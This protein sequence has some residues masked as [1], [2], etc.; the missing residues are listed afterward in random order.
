MSPEQ[1]QGTGRQAASADAGA[2]PTSSQS[3]RASLW[4]VL[5]FL[6][7][8]GLVVWK[9]LLPLVGGAPC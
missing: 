1:P 3:G 6:L 4:G 9:V 8:A 2:S 7:A 5:V